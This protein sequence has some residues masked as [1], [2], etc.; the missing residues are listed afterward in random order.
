MLA[1]VSYAAAFIAFAPGGLEAMALLA[2][3]LVG[4]GLLHLVPAVGVLGGAT[5]ERLYGAGPLSP[6][7]EL[8]LRHRAVLFGVLGALLVAAAWRP[9]LRTAAVIAG[10]VSMLAFVWLAWPVQAQPTAIARVFGADVVGSVVLGLAVLAAAR[11]GARHS[12]GSAP[13]RDRRT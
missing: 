9:T 10:L 6:E 7:L 13:G 5:L 3:A 12:V 11:R 1:K 8:L 2:V 4:V